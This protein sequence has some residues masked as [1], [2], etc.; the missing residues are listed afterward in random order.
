LTGSGGSGSGKCGIAI[1][2]KIPQKTRMEK[3]M[4]PPGNYPEE[5]N[6]FII[7]RELAK[8]D[9]ETYLNG[10]DRADLTGL[11]SRYQYAIQYRIKMLLAS[12]Q[13]PGVLKW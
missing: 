3:I 13:S 1:Y 4:R 5:I 12:E 11:I 10:V 7:A 8:D 9:R 2:Q 6:E